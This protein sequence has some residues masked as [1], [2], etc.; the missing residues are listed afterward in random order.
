[1]G[2]EL[3]LVSAVVARLPD[4][5]VSL[6]AYGGVVFPLALLIESP[7]IMLLSASTA[8]ARDLAVVPRWCA[9]FMWIAV[10]GAHRLPR[11]GRV[12]AAVRPRRRRACSACRPRCSSRR[13][14]ACSI[15]TPWTFVDRLPAHA[16]GRAHPLRPPARRERRHR[17]APGRHRRWC[18]PGLSATAACPAIAVGTLARRRRRGRRGGVTRAWPCARCCADRVRDAPRPTGDRSTMARF[19]RF[20]MPLALTPLIMLLR[21]AA[22]R[23]RP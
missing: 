8:L 2:L 14:S 4:P 23:P 17:G 12:H 3:P 1:M 9:A 22:R 7:I 20:Y 16:A 15:M 13:G 18:W 6:A 21:H 11:A 10:A 19:L 5:T